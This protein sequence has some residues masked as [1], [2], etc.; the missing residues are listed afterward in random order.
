MQRPFGLLV[1]LGCL[2]L[3]VSACDEEPPKRKHIDVLRNKLRSLEKA[4][5]AK[6]R[7]AIDSLL[8]VQILEEEQSSDSL[9]TFVYG[10]DRDFPFAG[11]SLIE[12]FYTGDKARIDVEIV[13]STGQIRRPAIL[14]LVYEHDR[15][16]FKKFEPGSQP[17]T[18][19]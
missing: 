15:W 13:D 19:P 4:V 8:S 14:T 18:E 6:N 9:L 11:F 16:L 1:L 3:L 17:V 12:M 2:L 5:V 10:R 7:A